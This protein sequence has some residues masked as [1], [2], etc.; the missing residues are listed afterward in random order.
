MRAQRQALLD[1]IAAA[2]RVKLRLC[3]DH[4]EYTDMEKHRALNDLYDA[5]GAAQQA[6]KDD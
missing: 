4:E 6:V 5:L 1:L 2:D 3:D